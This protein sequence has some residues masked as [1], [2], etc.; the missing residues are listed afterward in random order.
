MRHEILNENHIDFKRTIDLYK[1][2]F[3]QN[4]RFFVYQLKK[5]MKQKRIEILSLYEDNQYIGFCIITVINKYCYL[6]YFAIVNEKQ[7]Q[8]YGTKVLNYLRDTLNKYLIL[9]IEEIDP[10]YKN[11]EQ[12]IKRYNFYLK[13]K[14]KK[15]G[16]KFRVNYLVTYDIL[17]DTNI[18]KEEAFLILKTVYK[19][20]AFIKIY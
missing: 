7:N 13:N 15:T 9:E 17:C 18:S 19:N 4:E 16:Y 11:Y 20:K 2:S 14:L 3:P 6:S 8:G 10:K 5:M 12:R 1:F